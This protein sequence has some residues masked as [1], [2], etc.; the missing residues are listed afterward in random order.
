MANIGRL[1][2][3]FP[4]SPASDSYANVGSPLRSLAMLPQNAIVFL[5]T[6]FSFFVTI[7]NW[8]NTDHYVRFLFC[9]IFIYLGASS[10][11]SAY[12]RQFYVVVPAVLVWIA[13]ITDK[14]LI[15]KIKKVDS[16][17]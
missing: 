14:S 3:N 6:I 15:V 7:I 10:V 17:Q 12:S 9:F 5:M 11:V 8:K 1:F 13:Y 2:F 16:S 4:Y